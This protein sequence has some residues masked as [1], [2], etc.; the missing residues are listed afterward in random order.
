[1]S[2]PKGSPEEQI[3]KAR[4]LVL[5]QEFRDHVKE[6]RLE[7]GLTDERQIY[8]GWMIQKMANLQVLVARLIMRLNTI[9]P[10]G[11]GSLDAENAAMIAFAEDR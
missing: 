1:M 7:E 2:F 11:Q 9:A 3:L 5:I 10:D 8:E 6:C 4:A